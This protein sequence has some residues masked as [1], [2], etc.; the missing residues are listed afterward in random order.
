MVV[1]NRSLAPLLRT[2]QLAVR[3]QRG[4]NPV[5]QVFGRDTI[6]RRGVVKVFERNKP[7]LNV[8]KKVFRSR[9]AN[10]ADCIGTIGHVDHGKVHSNDSH[11]QSLFC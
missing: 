1:L 3:Q 5:Q 4:I 6:G 9:C 7:H 11:V 8:G 2:T 10:R